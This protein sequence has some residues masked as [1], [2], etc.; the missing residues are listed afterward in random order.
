MGDSLEEK[1]S[2]MFSSLKHPARRKI[3]KMLSERSMTFSEM[4]DKLEI[5]GSHLTYHLETLGEFVVKKEDGQYKLSSFGEASVSA[6]KGIEE[7]PSIQTIKFSSLPLR[8]KSLFALFIIFTLL[9]ASLSYVQYA[10]FN[11]LSKD[12]ELLQDDFERIKAQNQQLLLENTTDKS[13]IFLRSVVQIDLTQYQVT[14]LS[15]TVE[16]RHDL[17]GMVEE[18]FKYS[19]I[20]GDSKMDIVVRFRNNHFSL[21]QLSILEGF[22]PYAPKYVLSEFKDIIEVTIDIIESYKSIINEPYLEEISRLLASANE[23]S[24]ELTLGNTKLKMAINGDNAEIFLLYTEN[25]VDFAAK[26]LHLVFKNHA[27]Q[28]LSDDWFRYKVGNTQVNVSE[29]EAIQIAR[30]AAENFEW[31]ASGVQVSD[32]DI[33][34]EPVSALFFPHPRTDP[35]TLIPYWYIT[36]YLDRV[37]PGGVTSIAVGVWADTGVVSNIQALSGQAVT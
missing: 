27:L 34:N 8:W 5:P 25:G 17:G 26:S 1:Y 18:I 31:N 22:P 21:Y 9:F 29:E 2:T 33:L 16:E 6:M 11:Q 7:V 37:Y 15:R 3:L 32:F 24:T 4:L 35:L 28:E 19:L 36:L 12:Y 30:N 23:T 20:D 13:L 14:L 10:S